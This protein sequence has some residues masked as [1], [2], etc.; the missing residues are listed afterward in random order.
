MQKFA[1]H[2]LRFAEMQG[3]AAGRLHKKD[4]LMMLPIFFTLSTLS[5][6]S[7]TSFTPGMS[8]I[9]DLPSSSTSPIPFLNEEMAL[10]RPEPISGSF[11]PPKTR[12]AIARNYNKFRGS[13]SK[14]KASLAAKDYQQLIRLCWSRPCLL[15]LRRLSSW[16]FLPWRWRP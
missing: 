3:A 9:I 13:Q 4:Y 10:P 14:H 8:L 15:F 11:L 6:T 7:W 16:G 5:L 1:L 2:A 12:K